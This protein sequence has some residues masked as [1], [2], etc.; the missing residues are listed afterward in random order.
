MDLAEYDGSIRNEPIP[1]SFWNRLKHNFNIVKTC[2]CGLEFHRNVDTFHKQNPAF[3]KLLIIICITKDLPSLTLWKYVPHTDTGF[4]RNGGRYV[5]EMRLN[6]NIPKP[7]PGKYQVD[8]HWLEGFLL[9][10]CLW[11]TGGM[12]GWA[13]LRGW[14]RESAGCLRSNW[15][16][17]VSAEQVS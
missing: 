15:S 2:S 3:Y 13:V 17:R 11:L 12:T 6:A 14:R 7:G 4:V 8:R 5:S 9:R 10:A 1:F 16:T